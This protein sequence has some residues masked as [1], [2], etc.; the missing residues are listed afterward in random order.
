[1]KVIGQLHAATALRPGKN[2]STHWA[3]G[4]VGHRV[5]LDG[6]GIQKSPGSVVIRNPDRPAN[7]N[8]CFFFNWAHTI[9]SVYASEI[10]DFFLRDTLRLPPCMSVRH[11]IWLVFILHVQT[12]TDHTTEWHT[13]IRHYSF[14]YNHGDRVDLI[15]CKAPTTDCWVRAF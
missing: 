12:A 1:M 10:A 3:G 4:W 15:R 9:S 2:P 11:L 14:L 5:G 13:V 8:K 6:F 7:N